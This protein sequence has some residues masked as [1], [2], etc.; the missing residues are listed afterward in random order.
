[1]QIEDES[2]Y[3]SDLMEMA[4]KIRN[5]EELFE[6]LCHEALKR[7][8]KLCKEILMHQADIL[9]IDGALF[10]TLLNDLQTSENPWKALFSMLS[11]TP[12]IYGGA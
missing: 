7:A 9:E 6:M 3:I 8:E 11:E 4:F 1:M 2:R 5:N 12:R 10:E